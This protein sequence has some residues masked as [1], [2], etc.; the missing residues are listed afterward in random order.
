[1]R[2]S[3]EAAGGLLV[4][5]AALLFGG[6]VVLGKIVENSGLPVPAFLSI[7]FGVAA[8]LLAA[9]LAATRQPLR[10]ARGERLPLAALGTAGYAVESGLFF[11]ALRHGS[12]AAVTLL[13]FTYPVL[14]AVVAILMG[15]GLPGWLLGGSL[16]AAVGGAALVVLSSGGLDI[17]TAGIALAFAAALTFALYLTLAE[18]VLK[19]TGSITGSMWV[20]AAASVALGGLALASGGARWPGGWHEW[21]PVLTTAVFTAGAFVCLFAG[22]RRLGSVRTSIVAASEPLAATA[23]AVVFLNEPL[24]AGTVAGGVLIL[25]GAVAASLAR[26]REGGPPEVP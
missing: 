26:G 22:L 11:A 8:I 18:R 3:D 14:V 23:L 25:G 9:A 16:M 1:L 2:P 6:V 20:S 12:A 4:G 24:R 5:L 17:T 10:A 7:R 21:G 19:R 15:R 13:F